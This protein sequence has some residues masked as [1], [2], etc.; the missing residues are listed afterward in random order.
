MAATIRICI[1]NPDAKSDNFLRIA[2]L[3]QDGTQ[4]VDECTDWQPLQEHLRMRAADIVAV[5]FD[6][7]EF[8]RGLLMVERI[9]ELTPDVGVI[10]FS[11]ESAP[12][13][14]I[15][16]MRAGCAQFVRV[17]IDLNDLREAVRRLYKTRLPTTTGCQRIC[18]VGSSGG[19]G[20]TTIACN[21]ALELAAHTQR[22]CG[23][24]DMNLQFGDVACAFD[25]QPRHTIA[26]ICRPGID[27]DRTLVETVLEELPCKV[28]VL[29]RPEKIEESHEVNAESI[30]ELYHCLEQIFPFVVVDLPRSFGASTMATLDGADHV[31]LVSQLAVPFLRNAQRMYEYL[32]DVGAN[33]ERIHLVLNRCKATHERISPDDVEKQ[34]GKPVF[35]VVPNDYKHIG[36]SRD[37]GHP[38]MS[39]APNSPARLA[40]A[41]MAKA[42]TTPDGMEAATTASANGSFLGMFRRR[43]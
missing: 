36:A 6:A 5:N 16:A 9:I 7:D 39:D 20:T 41:E 15:A 18:V 3:E 40:I 30:Y 12:E 26:D 14:I 35:A 28:S 19:A 17:P 33:E 29:A 31:L 10:G 21:L 27:I 43:R 2:F 32:V 22:R 38:L 37:L 4:I 24:V 42:L 13:R 11:K 25:V 23:M 8:E 34:F 1:Y